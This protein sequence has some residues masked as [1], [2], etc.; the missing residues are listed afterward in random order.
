MKRLF[1]WFISL[2]TKKKPHSTYLDKDETLRLSHTILPQSYVN[3]TLE[4]DKK[5]YSNNI[6]TVE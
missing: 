4:D 5:D 1:L 6:V 2:F 3:H